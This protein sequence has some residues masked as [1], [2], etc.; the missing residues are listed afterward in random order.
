MAGDKAKKPDDVRAA[1]PDRNVPVGQAVKLSPPN[2]PGAQTATA[3][4]KGDEL[5]LDSPDVRM[6]TVAT[7]DNGLTDDQVGGMINVGPVQDLVHSERIGVYKRPD[8]STF[9]TRNIQDNKHDAQYRAG[10]GDG[11]QGVR[12]DVGRGSWYQTPATLS[13]QRRSA[14]VYFY[15]KPGFGAPLKKDGAVLQETKGEDRFVTSFAAARGDDK[16]THLWQAE[17]G[18]PWATK[19]DPAKRDYVLGTVEPTKTDKKPAA[20]DGDLPINGADWIGYPTQADANAAPTSQL[21][22]ALPMARGKDP[23]SYQFIKIALAAKNPQV[24][25]TVRCTNTYAWVGKDKVNMQIMSGSASRGEGFELNTNEQVAKTYAL[26]DL[27]NL[28]LYDGGDLRI[29]IQAEK[30]TFDE[31]KIKAPF[32][33]AAAMKDVPKSDGRYTVGV[34]RS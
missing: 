7:I 21:L 12:A 15:D 2:K 30:H 31:V 6:D 10:S 4:I 22:N 19:V 32:D 26:S 28:D 33:G 24:T 17:W 9:E 14:Q 25:I 16:P 34:T 8:G 18:V 27:V 11:G 1:L 29:A 13:A 3:Q 20:L 23:Q 5:A